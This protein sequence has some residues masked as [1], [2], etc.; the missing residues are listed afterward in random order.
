MEKL[1]YSRTPAI[2]FS[3]IYLILSII[4]SEP[5]SAKLPRK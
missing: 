3:G 1:Q 2:H 4:F 5:M